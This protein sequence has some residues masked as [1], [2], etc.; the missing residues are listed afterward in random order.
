MVLEFPE[1]LLVEYGYVSEHLSAEEVQTQLKWSLTIKKEKVTSEPELPQSI[2]AI[3]PELAKR[4]RE[5]KEIQFIDEE[6]SAL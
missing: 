2:N 3:A 6:F 1:T 4:I 5:K